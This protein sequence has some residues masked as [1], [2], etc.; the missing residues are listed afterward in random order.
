MLRAGRK[1]ATISGLGA[2]LPEQVVSNE[3]LSQ[4]LDTSDTW[5]AQRTGIRT[6]R[7]AAEG[8][9][10]SDLALPAARAA[11]EQAGLVPEQV[12][13]VILASISPDHLMPATAARVAG[14]LGAAKAGSL[15]VSAGCTG[16]VYALSLATGLVSSEMMQ[17]VLVVA[18]EAISRVLDW[19]DRSTAVLFGDAGGAAVVS[20]T[21]GPS[22]FLAF[23]F[24]TDGQGADLLTIPAGGSR[25][26]ASFDTI[27]RRQH[28][29]KMNGREVYRF[30]TRVVPRS[31]RS[32]LARAEVGMAEV[33][34]VV[35]HQ[36][37]TRIIEAVARELGVPWDR[38]YLNL[39]R[40]GNTSCASIPLSL[41]EAVE[42]GRI[43]EGDLVLLLGFGAGLTWGSCLLRWGAPLA[44]E[45]CSAAN[46]S[47]E[48][49]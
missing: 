18:G 12:D 2:F 9:S 26:P 40:Y 13:L 16:F 25:L 43:R 4:I 48:S 36:A 42:E 21:S 41:R 10:S 5:I 11:L 24:G 20:P 17:H 44:E 30:A 28:Y 23:D 39:D 34:L 38:V 3:D 46:S 35:P 7:R 15:D 33:S 47:Q 32:V 8:H 37:N 19:S 6:R 14:G 1:G 29:M 31:A 49:S 22:R 45:N 27:V